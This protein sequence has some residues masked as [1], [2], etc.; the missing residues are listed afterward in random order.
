MVKSMLRSPTLF[1]NILLLCITLRCSFA[2][3]YST[4]MHSSISLYSA[5]RYAAVF[6]STSCY[7][8]IF[9]I[10]LLQTLPLSKNTGH[11]ENGF[12]DGKGFNK[13]RGGM[14]LRVQSRDSSPRGAFTGKSR[15]TS[16]RD[17]YFFPFY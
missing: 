12:N 1:N 7:F 13:T 9:F 2:P 15:T 8:T 14:K 16:P 10:T 6:H 17:R 3:L 5:L 11:L 4:S